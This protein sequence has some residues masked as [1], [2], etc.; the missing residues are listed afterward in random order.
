MVQR[1]ADNFKPRVREKLAGGNR[2]ARIAQGD[3]RL[4]LGLERLECRTLLSVTSGLGVMGDSATAGSSVTKWPGMLQT[5]EGL[6]FGGAGLPYNFAVG[7]AT[8]GSVLSGGQDTELAAQV[9]AGNVT[10]G[11]ILIGNNDYGAQLNQIATG[12]LTGAALTSFQNTI[13][14]NIETATNTVLAAKPQGFILGSVPDITFEPISA[15]LDTNPT[16]KARVENSIS[17]VNSQL[18]AYAAARGIPYLNFYGLAGAL[19]GVTQIVVGGVPISLVNT[20]TDPHDFFLDTV[21]PGIVGDAIIANLWMAAINK[22]YGTNLPLFTDQQILGFAGLGSSYTGETFSTAV[23][24]SNFVTVT[25][26]SVVGRD[27]FYAN[28][29]YD[30]Q[31]NTALPWTPLAQSDDNAIASDKSAY[32]PGSGAATFGNVSSYIQGI[33]GIMVDLLGGGAHSAININDF[34]FKSGNTV[35]V[36]GTW[37]TLSGADLPTVSVRLGMTGAATA[38][39][40]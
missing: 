37:T 17:A 3:L 13:V 7:G 33:N 22:G 26:S 6:N 18:I 31:T 38:P 19:G 20:G 12:T 23:N 15:S 24:L 10:L 21:H 32:L 28:S 2:P 36:D 34:V 35:S 8:S 5:Y 30:K 11:M 25:P 4:G 29:G 27:L 39:A 9:S 14:S 1:R 16:E 40:R